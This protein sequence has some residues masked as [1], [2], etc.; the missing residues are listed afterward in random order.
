MERVPAAPTSS[1]AGTRQARAETSTAPGAGRSRRV[2][3]GLGGPDNTR[4]SYRGVRQRRWG[5]WVAEIRDPYGGRRYWLGSFDTPVDAAVAYDRAAVAIHGTLARLNFPADPAAASLP[6]P[7]QSLPASPAAAVP[8]AGA[9]AVAAQRQ[10]G[11]ASC[12]PTAASTVD[13]FQEHEAKPMVAGALGGG[14]AITT[15]QG[16]TSWAAPGP[17]PGPEEMFGDC[18]EDIAMYIDFDAVAGV[19]PCYPGIKREDCQPD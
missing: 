6:A 5:K 7:A 1:A 16:G 11:P 12:S 3:R 9:S 8:T 10:W 19:V 17:E 18:S 4:H 2:P 15:Q 14:A 13:V